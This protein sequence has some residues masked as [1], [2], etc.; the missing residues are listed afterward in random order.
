MQAFYGSLS[1][2]DLRLNEADPC[3]TPPA[4]VLTH[5]V[6]NLLL[7]RQRLN[8]HWA[9]DKPARESGLNKAK[10]FQES[11]LQPRQGRP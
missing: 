7:L 1:Q 9:L 6:E 2:R 4:V 11:V 3:R 5:A 8:V 10:R